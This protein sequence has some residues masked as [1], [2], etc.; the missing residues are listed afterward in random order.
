[1]TSVAR[2]VA[3]LEDTIVAVATPG[4]RGALALIR[5]SG[6]DA[7]AIAAKHLQPAPSQMRAVQLCSVYNGDEVLDQAIVTFFPSPNSF[8]GDDTVEFSTHGGY[9]VPTSVIATLISSGARQALPGEFT[10]RAVLNGKLDILQAEAIGDLIDARSHVMQR[11]ALGQLDG[12]LS[13][14]L[15]SLRDDLID[16][17][18]L[19]VYDIDFPE[20]DDGPISRERVEKAA[21]EVGESL[22]MLLA[23]APVGELIREGA[24]VVIAGRP[25]VGKSSLFNALLGRS[26]AIVTEI[27]GTTRDALEAVIDD[28]EWPLRLVDT[29]GLRETNDRIERM[30]IEV[31]ERYLV[32]AHVVLAC[33]ESPEQLKETINVIAKESSAPVV[34]VRTKADLVAGRDQSVEFHPHVVVSAE[35]GLGL[36]DLLE[37]IDE[38]LREKHGEIIPDLPILTRARHRQAL[39]VACSEIEQFRRA[40]KEE[41]LPATIASIHLRTAVSTLEELIGTVEVE[42]VFD[43]VFSS[44]CVGK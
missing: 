17:E 32:E 43:R 37:V 25:N 21:T 33:G 3:Q 16:L 40:W 26:R 22:R 36:Q 44:F 27:P 31:S 34:A 28:G 1:V 15:L 4:G 41:N 5:L 13:R 18:A 35:T 38:V 24:V 10:R 7:F 23:T 20:E 2:S 42:D 12:G 11:A 8:T 9:L 29:A 6:P 19:I 39:T 14:R 30:G